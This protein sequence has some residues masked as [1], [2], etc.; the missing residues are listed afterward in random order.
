[1]ED[2]F[3]AMASILLRMFNKQLEIEKV[4]LADAEAEH[5]KSLEWQFLAEKTEKEE[6]KRK[7][8]KAL[9]A[10]ILVMEELESEIKTLN[11]IIHGK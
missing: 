6:R 1:M 5:K 7:C 9:N 10:Q 2:K 3:K 4:K 11:D 8:V